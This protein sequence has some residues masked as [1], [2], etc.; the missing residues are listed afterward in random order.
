MGRP[1]LDFYRCTRWL[2]SG[3]TGAANAA[4]ATRLARVTSTPAPKAAARSN[5]KCMIKLPVHDL[6]YP[7][8]RSRPLSEVT[9]RGGRSRGRTMTKPRAAW[10]VPHDRA[11]HASVRGLVK[12]VRD[13][14][15]FL[16]EFSCGSIAIPDRPVQ[17][18]HAPHFRGAF[19]WREAARASPLERPP[20]FAVLAVR[21]RLT[22]ASGLAMPRFF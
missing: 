15:A 8:A 12:V 1:G 19:L 7:L 9:D 11:V 13:C 4:R 17:A 20:L 3:R 10:N 21:L 22:R 18:P 16:W 2:R 5:T 14:A 6:A